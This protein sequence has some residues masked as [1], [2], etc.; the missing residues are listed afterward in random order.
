MNLSLIRLIII[1]S[2]PLIIAS[3]GGIF[4]SQAGI[5]NVALDG[6]ILMGAFF[7]VTFSY[8]FG[9][10]TMGVIG[11]VMASLLLSLL[12]S[13]FVT[14]LKANNFAIGF[15][16]NIFVGSITVYLMRIMFVGQNAFN[17]PDIKAI[18]KLNIDFGIDVLNTLFADYS[19]LTYLAFALVFIV[20]YV[21]YKTPFGMWLRATGSNPN[22]L[23]TAGKKVTVIQYVASM[24]TGVFCGLAGAQLS[25]SNVV[26]FTKNMSAGR[27]FI[28]L[29][30]MFIARDNPKVAMA[31]A[32]LF[33]LFEALSIKLQVLSVPPHFLFMLPYVIAIGSLIISS[34]TVKIKKN[35]RIKKSIA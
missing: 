8:L 21:L 33:G 17:S 22:A 4:T 2:T 5:V 19:I 18:P 14:T 23:K 26:M 9:S 20:S 13:F 24:I 12:Y 29:A 32:L 11:A 35:S 7:A 27:G 3:L 30:V 16:I 15:A 25:L 34:I 28:C 10:A 6:L 31:L 1:R